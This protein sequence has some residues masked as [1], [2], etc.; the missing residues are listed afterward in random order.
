MNT[1]FLLIAFKDISFDATLDKYHDNLVNTIK[2]A[3]KSTV[4][5]LEH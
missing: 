4:G 2:A 5:S 3:C 1:I